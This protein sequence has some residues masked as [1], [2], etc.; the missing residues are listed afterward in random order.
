[1]LSFLHVVDPVDP[2]LL[3]LPF[4]LVQHDSNDEA[5]IDATF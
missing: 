2:N 3:Y 4:E 5:S 1:M